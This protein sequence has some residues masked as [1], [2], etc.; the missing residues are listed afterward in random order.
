MT[1]DPGTG[2]IHVGDGAPQEGVSREDVAAVVAAALVEP[3]TTH[4]MIEFL[5]GDVPVGQALRD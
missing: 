3:S 2:R 1:D 4:R 5:G